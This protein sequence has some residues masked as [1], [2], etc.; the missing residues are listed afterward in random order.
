MNYFALQIK[1]REE[2]K[3]MTLA[4]KNHALGQLRMV[5]PRRKLRIKRRGKFRHVLAPLFPGYIFLSGD[6]ILPETY[7]KIR[8]IPGF[9]RFLKSNSD[10]QPLKG[11]ERELL[12][13]FLSYGE[14][15]KKSTVVFDKNSRIQ[16]LE[17]PLKGLEGHIVKVDKRKGRAKIRLDMYDDFFLV[18][19]GID[20]LEKIPEPPGD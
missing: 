10:I 8:R 15:I 2:S 17:G 6:E 16:V 9:F 12:L 11:R 19:L 13:H 3:F 7:W 4:E 18:D 20:I 5:F 14:V 1:T